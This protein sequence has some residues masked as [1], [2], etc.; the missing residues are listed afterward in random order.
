[1]IVPE[2]KLLLLFLVAVF[3]LVLGFVTISPGDALQVMI[4]GGYWIMLVVTALFAW[5]LYKIGRSEWRG[6]KDI[7]H[8][9]RWPAVLILACGCV[10]LVHEAYGFKILMD[11][12]MLLGTSMSLHFD[13]MALVPMRG[14]DIQGAFQVLGGDLDKRPLFH[15]FL[16]SLLHDI[17]G[18]RPE[19]VFVLN[20]LLTFLLLTLSYLT[21]FRIGGRGAGALAVFL[22][23]SIPLLAQNAT[24]GGFEI[25]N[26]VM[27]LATLLL[28]IRYAIRRDGDSLEAFGLSAILLSQT[29]YESAL[30]LL[31][32]VLTVLWVWWSDRKIS[33]PWPVIVM[34]LLLVP[35]VLHNKIFSARTSSWE[36]ASQPGFN[37]PFSFS[38]I[39]D[40]I[41]HD[42]NFFFSTNGYQSNSLILS[43][44][45][46]IAL[47]FFALWAVKVLSA[48]KNA[49]P[50]K[51]VI[52]F[53]SLGFAA[54]ALLMLCYFW[55]RFDDPVIRRL[56]LPFH[57]TLML[58]TLVTAVELNWK[59]RIWPILA[60]VVGV[61]FF[62]QS[63][64]TMSR[65]SYTSEYY[66]GREMEWRRQFIAEHPEKDYLFIDNSSIIWITH[67]ISATTVQQAREHKENIIFNQKNRI[68]S[69]IYV[70]QR[71][72]VDPETGA[73]SLRDKNGKVDDD[74]GSDYQLE[75][76]W[77]RRFTPL[78]VSRISRVVSIREGPTT[79]PQTAPVSLE[80]ISPEERE[81]IR[82]AYLE[83]FIKRLP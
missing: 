39:A 77:E 42:L 6:W 7:W 11:E 58:A 65:H 17:F 64:P 51:C 44:V 59:G 45:G 47:P 16:V 78:T 23:T 56:S 49:E 19:N 3:S 55:G 33:F 10:L 15:P 50:I 8:Q 36:M 1:M 69:T 22:L 74:L 38:Y 18:Y 25:L 62:A 37:R 72:S 71:Y 75:T 67:L 82:Q 34:P 20:T 27:I 60:A 79:P 52:A 2:R 54:H 26:L 21:G 46:F 30:F 48:L 28:G 80:K 24:G 57:L 53:F 43:V 31:P 70:F 4:Y 73:L 81:K 13:K 5:A 12:V 76:V 35:C 9:P 32:V 41:G 63:V 29:R 61:G 83:N 14:H 66:Y 40:N 68:F